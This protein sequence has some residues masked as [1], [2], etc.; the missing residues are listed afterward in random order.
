MSAYSFTDEGGP[1]P[2]DDAAVVSFLQGLRLHEA[3][4]LV[5]PRTVLVAS[6]A[7]GAEWSRSVPSGVTWLPLS[8]AY[9]FVS[10]A[11]VANRNPAVTFGDGTT[12]YGWTDTPI[13]VAASTTLRLAYM[14]GVGVSSQTGLASR[15]VTALPTVPLPGNHQLASVTA[16]LDAGDQYS[17]I[18]LQVLEIRERSAAELARYAD[19]VFAGGQAELFPGLTIGL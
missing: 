17:A 8:L 11:V 14:R 10:S 19:D 16:G 2:L 6:P 3:R 1:A 7:A 12:V 9:T 5:V 18:V 13:A 15:V 4:W